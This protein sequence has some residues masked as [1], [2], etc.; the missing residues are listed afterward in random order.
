MR[1]DCCGVRDEMNISIT[2]DH[3]EESSVSIKIVNRPEEEMFRH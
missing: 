2:K 1:R 3:G